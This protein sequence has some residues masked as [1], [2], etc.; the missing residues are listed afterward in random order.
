MLPLILDAIAPGDIKTDHPTA[1][2]VFI[3]V[4]AVVAVVTAIITRRKK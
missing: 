4:V 3:L 1:L 2:I